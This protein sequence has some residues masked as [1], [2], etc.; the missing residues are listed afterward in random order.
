MTVRGGGKVT[1][2]ENGGL[3]WE[4]QGQDWTLLNEVFPAL[5]QEFA[6]L[7]LSGR[8][9]PC[10]YH[11]FSRIVSHFLL[12]LRWVILTRIHTTLEMPSLQKN[13]LSLE[14]GP[15]PA[16]EDSI[17]EIM[18]TIYLLSTGKVKY[19]TSNAHKGFSHKIPANINHFYFM[20]I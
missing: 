1:V 11:L 19:I 7:Q 20:F 12:L 16:S 13:V 17:Q 8:G 2:Q 9:S 5:P 10:S 15:L 4:R 14:L 3:T 18:A 6:H